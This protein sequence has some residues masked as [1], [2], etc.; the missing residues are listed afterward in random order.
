VI[1]NERGVRSAYTVG[2][3]T[4]WGDGVPIVRRKGGRGRRGG[5]G[6]PK[7]W[8]LE[9]PSFYRLKLREVKIKCSEN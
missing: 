9:N 8:N 2:Q 3:V 1:Y 4:G 5:K 7:R 6:I